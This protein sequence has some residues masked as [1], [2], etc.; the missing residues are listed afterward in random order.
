MDFLSSISPL[1]ADVPLAIFTVAAVVFIIYRVL[2]QQGKDSDNQDRTTEKIFTLFARNMEV[3]DKLES[4]I[5]LLSETQEK[6]NE[7]NAAALK[8]HNDDV[9]SALRDTEG[10]IIHEIKQVGKPNESQSAPTVADRV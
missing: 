1:L 9:L 10:R 8:A 6:I 4:A 7:Y 5:I 2:V 3:T